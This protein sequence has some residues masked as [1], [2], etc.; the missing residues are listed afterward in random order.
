MTVTSGPFP[1][2]NTSAVAC[3]SAVG[4]VTPGDQHAPVGQQRRGL[5]GPGG[6]HR[7][8]RYPERRARLVDLGD[9]RVAA[10]DQHPAV[11]QQRGRLARVLGRHGGRGAPGPGGRVVQLGARIPGAGAA[12]AALVEPAGDQHLPGAQQRGGLLLPGGVHRA[13]ARPRP[14]AGS[15]SSAVLVSLQKS[16]SQETNPPATSTLPLYSR[17]AVEAR[18]RAHGAGHCPP[19][20]GRVIQLS[21]RQVGQEAARVTAVP[22]PLHPP[23]AISTLPSGSSVAV[24]PRPGYVHRASG[25]PGTAAGRTAPRWPPD[26]CRALRR[27]PAPSP[28]GS[29]VA[30]ASVT[31]TGIGPVGANARVAGHTVPRVAEPPPATSTLPP[32]SSVAVCPT[33]PRASNRPGSTYWAP[34]AT[35]PPPP[36]LKAAPLSRP[37]RWR[38]PRTRPP[39]GGRPWTTASFM[40]PCPGNRVQRSAVELFPSFR[41]NLRKP[42]HDRA[43]S[44]VRYR[45]REAVSWLGCGDGRTLRYHPHRSVADAALARGRPRSVSRR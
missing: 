11:G 27:P 42:P 44:A 16:S 1:A 36:P 20:G 7:A 32:G 24:C 37:P 39:A 35:V 6:A 43:R 19:A 38:R 25:R 31:A 12:E 18:G 8:R 29:N 41:P 13:G 5:V 14:G 4:A 2:R 17:V 34:P 9:R 15:Y 10:G 30:V 22:W 23:P 33:A 28:P 45:A 21:T 40:P 26:G 3:G